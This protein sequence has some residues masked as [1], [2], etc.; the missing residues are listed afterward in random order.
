M[1]PGPDGVVVAVLTF[2]RNAQLAQLLPLLIEQAAM[3]QPPAEVLVV[4]NDPHAAAATIAG[5]WAV[6]YVHEPRPGISA[7]R[8]RALD[9]A[10][11][12]GALV[13][14]DDDGIPAPGLARHIGRTLARMAVRCRRR[15]RGADLG[16]APVSS[17]VRASAAFAPAV[18]PTGASM[19]G[20]GTGNLLLDV[21]QI[22]RMGVRFEESLGLTG[23]EDTMF[24]HTLVSRGGAIRWCQ[25]AVVAD[26]IAPDRVTRS[27]ILRRD[28][29]AGTTW[30]AMELTLA[31]SGRRRMC[32]RASLLARGVIKVPL[33]VAGL[34]L[35]TIARD[36]VRAASGLRTAVSYL[37]MLCG[38][39]GYY[40]QEYRR[41]PDATGTRADE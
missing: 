14:I 6:T 7:A 30:S 28:L 31:G 12:A 21:P 33:G 39:V 16:G 13:F 35:G 41:Q 37:G 8:N 20:A 22:A 17:W 36:R 26:I 29:R 27:W 9:H 10:A 34:A 15:P 2:R 5:Q 19:P 25:D 38:A 11:E 40:P 18:H 23:G 32:T 4:D 3:V 24:T 1:T